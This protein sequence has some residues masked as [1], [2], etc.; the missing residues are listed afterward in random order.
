MTRLILALAITSIA[1]LGG[2]KALGQVLREYPPVDPFQAE[3]F[4]YFPY[5]YHMY[6]EIDGM[7]MSCQYTG[8]PDAVVTCVP[9]NSFHVFPFPEEY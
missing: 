9:H 1:C 6:T 7:A 5:G 3:N 8:M 2:A 4:Q